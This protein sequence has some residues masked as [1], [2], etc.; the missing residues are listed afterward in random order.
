[1]TNQE[2]HDLNPSEGLD[3]YLS[4]REP[5]L[6]EATIKT[7]RARIRIFTEW[8]DENEIESLRE[9]DGMDLHRYRMSVAEGI[10][11]KTLACRLSAV[12]NFLRWVSNV[13]AVDPELPER[14]SV[15][16]ADRARSRHLEKGAA[17]AILEYLQRFSYAS[18]DHAAILLFWRSGARLG[19]IRG[20]DIEDYYPEEQYIAFR[21]RP[22]TGTPLK[23]GPDG[24]RPI[25]LSTETCLVID[26]Y[27]E[28]NRRDES[29]ENGREP[30]LTT[31]HG[32]ISE[33]ALRRT[34]YRL[35]RPCVYDGECPHDRSRDDCEAAQEADQASQ[36]PSTVSP[37]DIR[38]GGIT[39]LCRNDVPTTAISD[40]CDVSPEVLEKHYNQMTEG[41][42]MEQRREYLPK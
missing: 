7:I 31:C 8:C 35:T 6:R 1:M 33:V 5:E 17:E 18:R 9:L 28:R 40:R 38:R 42:K 3:L 34:V 20:L 22:E 27:L 19:A 21:H 39:Y 30:L 29:G 24:E 37:H 11:R 16:R 10:S 14:I 23:N 4:E 12:R 13:E 41:E 26:D 2:L 15:P 25:A 32:R 36:C